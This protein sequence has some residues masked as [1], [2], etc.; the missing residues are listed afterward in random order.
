MQQNSSI[1]IAIVFISSFL[2]CTPKSSSGDLWPHNWTMDKDFDM[3]TPK[4]KKTKA[5]RYF[6]F[7]PEMITVPTSKM[8]IDP[9]DNSAKIEIGAFYLSNA[10]IT[11]FQYI[12]FLNNCDTVS[13]KIDK[14]IDM[15]TKNS[16]IKKVDGKFLIDEGFEDHPV[17]NV[18]YYGATEYCKW[19]SDWDNVNREKIGLPFNPNYRLPSFCE[20]NIAS[21]G[22]APKD[23][24][25]A[26]N[27]RL[28]ENIADFAWYDK[29][30]A[31]KL[32][33]AGQ[34]EAN[35]LKIYD[36]KGNAAEWVGDID[37]RRNNVPSYSSNPFFPNEDSSSICGGAYNSTRSELEYLK[38][39]VVPKNT[40][41]PSV[42]FRICMSYLGRSSGFEF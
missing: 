14:L 41:S 22:M 26:R 17:V 3:F 30:S 40:M 28:P 11:N 23:T 12:F 10:E 16:H 29:N 7:V 32:N 13:A 15:N 5:K 18:S 21:L 4:F 37:F 35:N 39:N 8:R 31:D 24:N 9:S 34:L 27:Y 42:G 20:L 1:F 2:G 25:E 33:R 38:N 36:I 19:L 6:S